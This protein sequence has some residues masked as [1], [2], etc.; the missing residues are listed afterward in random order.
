MDVYGC[1]PVFSFGVLLALV[2]R[3][4]SNPAVCVEESFSKM[5]K[6]KEIAPESMQFAWL[7]LLMSNCAPYV[8]F[9]MNYDD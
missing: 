5:L 3:K 4:I 9:S 1:V 7:P 2:F 6:Q 8:V